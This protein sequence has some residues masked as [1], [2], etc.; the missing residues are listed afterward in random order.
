ME[1]NDIVA[2]LEEHNVRPT[3]NRII[4]AGALA[5]AGM[6]MSLAELETEI[7]SIDKSNI[8]RALVSFKDNHLVHAIEDGSNGVR[9][10][11]CKSHDHDH[12]EDLHVHFHC[13]ICGKTF[14]FEDI[15][16]PKVDVPEGYQP[17]STNYIIKGICPSCQK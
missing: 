6:P 14:C 13:E 1:T 16:V 17:I 5:K 10:E 4:V 11:L 3:A 7:D 2:L 8:F 9:Y 15:P 12:D